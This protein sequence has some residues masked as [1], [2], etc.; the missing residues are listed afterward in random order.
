MSAKPGSVVVKSIVY[1]P[2]SARNVNNAPQVNRPA[3][4]T[5]FT[6]KPPPTPAFSDISLPQHLS[7]TPE[8]IEE[9]T[10]VASKHNKYINRSQSALGTYQPAAVDYR[11][12]TPAGSLS[13]RIATPSDI[14]S[15]YR[16][17]L[18]SAQ[19]QSIYHKTHVSGDNINPGFVPVL[20][21]WVSNANDY[22]EYYFGLPNKHY[23]TYIFHMDLMQYFDFFS[24]KYFYYQHFIKNNEKTMI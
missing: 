20:Q 3:S 18:A 15:V 21:S 4:R 23:H 5:A 7:V 10:T 19:P 1:R 9:Y 11:S 8:P 2:T 13:A 17:V 16:D 24:L 12:P 14:Q 6:P 22:G